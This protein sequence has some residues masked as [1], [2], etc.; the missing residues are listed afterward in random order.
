MLKLFVHY[1]L[2]TLTLLIYCHTFVD[3]DRRVTSSTVII[4]KQ[5]TFRSM[6]GFLQRHW[7]SQRSL[8]LNIQEQ[9]VSQPTSCLIRL[10]STEEN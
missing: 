1:C 7:F 3:A 6:H 8:L 9:S 4:N 10:S 5:L 2:K